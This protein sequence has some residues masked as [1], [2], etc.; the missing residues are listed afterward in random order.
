MRIAHEE[1]L[2]V[3]PPGDGTFESLRIGDAADE[4]LVAAGRGLA[5]A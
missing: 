1:G 3:G 2:P 5:T 4:P